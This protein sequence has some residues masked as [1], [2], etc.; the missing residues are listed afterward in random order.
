MINEREMEK[1]LLK[2]SIIIPTYN[3]EK[4][5][6]ACLQSLSN[7]EYKKTLIEVI[8]IDNGST[9][10]TRDIAEKY[11]D[12]LLSND[13]KNVSG[14]RNMGAN[15]SSGDI[16]AFLDADCIVSKKWLKSAALYF[17][18]LDVAAWGAPPVP[19]DDSSWVQR[20]WFL[21]REKDSQ[22]EEVD[23]LESMNLFVRKDTFLLNKGF[24]E[25]LV[26]CEDVDFSYRI[27]KFG[28]IISDR[29]IRVIHQGEA[30]TVREFM[31]KEIWRGRSNLQG[32]FSHGLSLKELPSLSIPVYFIFLTILMAGVIVSLNLLWLEIC[33]FLLVFPSVVVLFKKRKR[34]TNIFITCQLFFLIHIYFLSRTIAV[35]KKA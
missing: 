26:T 35:F 21:I 19:P 29:R 30:R 16:L 14:L 9:D 17:D 15:E 34:L 23:W 13:V 27:K 3:E 20:T 22:I 8:V 32:V 28:R 5:L 7:Q 33:F 18:K 24:N 12:I 1:K 6:P 11:A 10:K 2:V 25:D 4:H 31:K